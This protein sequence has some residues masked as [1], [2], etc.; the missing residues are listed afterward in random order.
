M[1]QTFAQLGKARVE[2][3]SKPSPEPPLDAAVFGDRTCSTVASVRWVARHLK[4]K[5]GPQDAPSAEAW[6]LYCWARQHEHDFWK[7]PYMQ[8]MPARSS[9]DP[10]AAAPPVDA[11]ESDL[12]A[13]EE[14]LLEGSGGSQGA[15]GEPQGSPAAAEVGDL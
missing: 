4:V 11:N 14:I 5:V 10:A 8:L 12:R 13:L 15:G 1:A 2:V 9:E 6:G 7:G 3:P